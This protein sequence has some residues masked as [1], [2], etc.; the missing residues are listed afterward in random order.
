MDSLLTATK[1]DIE[2][3][4]DTTLTNK[5]EALIEPNED[6]S[7]PKPLEKSSTIE[8]RDFVSYELR[9]KYINDLQVR[10]FCDKHKIDI[11]KEKTIDIV[12]HF[13]KFYETVETTHVSNLNPVVIRL[14]GNKFSTWTKP[15]KRQKKLYDERIH[16]AMLNTCS[17]LVVKFQ[18]ATG[19]TQSD[20][21]T[22]IFKFE[23]DGKENGN[24]Y[25]GRIVKLATIAS[26]YAAARFNYHMMK[27]IPSYKL[28]DALN[29][30]SDYGTKKKN[31]QQETSGKTKKKSQQQ[32][33]PEEIER[34]IIGH[35]LACKACFD[36]RVFNLPDQ[37]AVLDNL[38]W[39]SI[40]DRIRNSVAGLAKIHATKQEIEGKNTEKL[41]MM[42]REKG[43][44]WEDQPDWFKIGIFVKMKNVKIDV[45]PKYKGLTGATATTMRTIIEARTI[46]PEDLFSNGI[47]LLFS[48]YWDDK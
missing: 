6:E 1:M 44:D 19:Y 23:Q 42:L 39:R 46:T 12:G 40:L 30:P 24:L 3:K 41:E 7:L 10:Y 13:M 27:Q 21:I 31:T 33:T 15:F 16:I 43:I 32:E 17:D 38:I 18:A 22:L 8:F 20:E 37:E 11:H 36:A 35:I 2:R 9:S 5:D 26:S 4:D 14:D 47:K 48:K 28:I 45:D 34:R 25:K 29:N